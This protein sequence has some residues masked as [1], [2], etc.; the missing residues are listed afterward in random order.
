V[1]LFFQQPH[2]EAMMINRAIL[3]ATALFFALSPC[4]YADP[5][6][7]QG[8]VQR[9]SAED[10][11]SLIDAHIEVLKAALQ[12]TPEQQKNWPAVEDAIRS[13]AQNRQERRSARIAEF[14]DRSII[15]IIR[16]RDP[17]KFLNRRADALAERSADL[18]KLSSAWEPL[19]T[20]L[21]QDQKRR[22]TLLT[23][24]VLRDVQHAIEERRMQDEDDDDYDD[25]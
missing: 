2:W 13:L 1:L 7:D 4:A 23:I 5:P 11:K 20:S 6:R 22:L 24:V 10:R 17:V 14:R 8:G 19:Y 3:G 12:L 18:K 16:N 21:S 25:H 9:L 15:D